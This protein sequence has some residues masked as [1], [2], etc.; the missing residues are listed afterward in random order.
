MKIQYLF[1]SQ[2]LTSLHQ[3]DKEILSG[4]D[5]SHLSQVQQLN[6]HLLKPNNNNKRKI[7]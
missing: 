3:D 4:M 5:H 2:E 6:Y 1:P 7:F